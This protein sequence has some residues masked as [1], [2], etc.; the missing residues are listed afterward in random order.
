MAGKTMQWE[1]TGSVFVI[2]HSPL[3]PTVSEYDQALAGYDQHLG[4][5]NGILIHSEGGAPNALQ[6]KRTTEFWEGK[7]LPKTAIMTSSSV[8]RG[9]ITALNWFFPQELRCPSDGYFQGAFEYLAVPQDQ[10]KLVTQTVH[11]LRRELG[12]S[13]LSEA[14]RA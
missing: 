10:Q 13:T 14:P 5:F 3:N 2:V 4:R 6:R 11:R 8:V 1:R 12:I 9:V 7:T